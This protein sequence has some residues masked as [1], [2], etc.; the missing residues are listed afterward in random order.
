MRASRTIRL[1]HTGSAVILI[2]FIAVHLANHLAGLAGIAA[3]QAFMDAAR[4]IYRAPFL[5][6]VLLAAVG[7]QVVTGFLQLRAGWGLRRDA[8]SRLQALSGG[9]LLFFLLNHTVS[10]LAIRTGLGLDSDF[11]LAAAVLT[12]APLPLFFVPYYLLA[13]LAVATH[14]ACAVRFRTGHVRAAKG[15]IAAG[16]ILAPVIVAVFMG[17]FFEINLP[18]PYYDLIARFS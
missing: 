8:W 2:A 7:V 13:I 16:A 9:Y 1:V 11:Y 15:I 6:P 5:E 4:R 10:V 3:H 12:I 14:L 17:V 18:R